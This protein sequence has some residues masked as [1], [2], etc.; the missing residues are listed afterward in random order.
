[1]KIFFETIHL[2][3]KDR[4]DIIDITNYIETI[5]TNNNVRDGYALIFVPGSTGALTT[6]EYESGVL[7]DLKKA[8]ER[9][10]PDDIPYEHDLRWGDGNGFSHVRAALLGPS[11]NI[12]IK[13]GKL[14]R[15]TW[16]Q[17][18]FI[19]FDNRPREREIIVQILGEVKK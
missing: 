15:G 8:I 19:D 6:I 10:V 16:Q 13:S 11:L 4:I 2:S 14:L 17:I 1:M 7:N 12:P 3:S 5:V 18:V 9:I